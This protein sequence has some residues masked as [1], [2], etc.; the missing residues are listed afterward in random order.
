MAA[1]ALTKAQDY[2]VRMN[3]FGSKEVAWSLLVSSEFRVE[4]RSWKH[5][6]CGACAHNFHFL[7]AS[8]GV[9]IAQQNYTNFSVEKHWQGNKNLPIDGHSI[10]HSDRTTDGD[11]RFAE[12]RALFGC[13]IITFA[14][15]PRHNGLSWCCVRFLELPVWWLRVNACGTFAN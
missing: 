10:H 8:S 7:F 12:H 6:L 13:P 2:I 9:L 15:L 14:K 1:P 4:G 3:A 11:C 5:L